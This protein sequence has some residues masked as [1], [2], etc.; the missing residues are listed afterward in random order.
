MELKTLEELKRDLN[1]LSFFYLKVLNSYFIQS[2]LYSNFSEASF[3]CSVSLHKV[4]CPVVM[5]LRQK[6]HSQIMHKMGDATRSLHIEAQ[7]WCSFG[8]QFRIIDMNKKF[9]LED[10]L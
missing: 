6:N 8:L 9:R 10:S 7:R 2:K 4:S 5:P 1:N 3:F